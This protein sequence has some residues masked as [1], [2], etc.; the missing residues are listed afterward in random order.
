MAF[1]VSVGSESVHDGSLE[2]ELDENDD[3]QRAY[4]LQQTF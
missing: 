4:K 3:L 2:E 1:I